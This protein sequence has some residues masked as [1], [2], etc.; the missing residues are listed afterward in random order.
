M[1]RGHRLFKARSIK[2]GLPPGT[3]V[4]IGETP[5][6]ATSITRI[7]YTDSDFSEQAFDSI[8]ACLPLKPSKGVTWLNLEGLNDVESIRRLGESINLHPLVLEDI[9]ST[10]QRPKVEDYDEYLFI[11]VKM[12]LPQQNGDFASE[13]L[14]LV[15]GRNYLLTFQE[16]IKGD[17]FAPIRERARTGKGKLR[18]LGVDYLAYSLLD[19][20]VDSYFSVLEGFGERLIVIEEEIALHPKPRVLV[21]LNEMKKEAIFLRKSVWPLR[22][23]ISFLERDD[24]ELIGE[25]TRLYLRDVHDHTVQVIET[26]ETYRDL[27]S[28]MLD[29]YLSSLS[30]RTNEVMKFL[31]IVGTIFMPL[32]FIVGVYGMNFKNMPELEWHYG[33]YLVLGVMTAITMG[34]ILY[35]RHRKWL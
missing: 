15:I 27:L 32:T 3:L 7:S 10:V 11:V 8:D 18:G 9:V 29:L 24:T 12:L 4:H 17:V 26:I 20:I 19:S 1:K 13:Q 5:L 31:T 35:F 23:V 22:E 33:Y 34:M 28:G 6:D 30:N 14:S 25:H 21:Q 16:G 2:A